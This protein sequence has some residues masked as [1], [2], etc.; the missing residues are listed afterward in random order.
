MGAMVAENRDSAEKLRR[1]GVMGASGCRA[2]ARAD[3][4]R[5]AARRPIRVGGC[6]GRAAGAARP[7]PGDERRVGLVGMAVAAVLSAAV[8]ACL[9]GIAHWRAPAH[10]GPSDPVVVQ[11]YGSVSPSLPSPASPPAPQ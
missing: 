1:S 8:V 4:A 6:A 9:L 11:V 5:P 7:A 3:W 10:M 2:V